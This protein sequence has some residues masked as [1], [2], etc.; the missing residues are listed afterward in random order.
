MMCLQVI[1]AFFCL[2]QA[3]VPDRIS[4][5]V[6][7]INNCPKLCECS[8]GSAGP[9]RTADVFSV[10]S[11]SSRQGPGGGGGSQS[12]WYA[13]TRQ[14]GLAARTCTH[15]THMSW[16]SSVAALGAGTHGRHTYSCEGLGCRGAILCL[17]GLTTG[18]HTAAEAS[19]V[20]KVVGAAAPLQ[21]LVARK[22][23]EAGQRPEVGTD[24]GP[25]AA[26]GTLTV[27]LHSCGCRVLSQVL[28]WPR[29]PG[30][31]VRLVASGHTGR[32]RP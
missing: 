24:L 30:M 19:P 7:D 16:Q 8:G 17:Q 4:L 10:T 27:S 5:G 31:G 18:V 11:R 12:R 23:R 9:A 14:Q 1:C 15:C 13:L 26:V 6:H 22:P 28:T 20:V 25:R 21:G 32:G 2:V 29:R 3:L